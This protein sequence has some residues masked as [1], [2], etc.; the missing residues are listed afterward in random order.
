M[1]R[2]RFYEDIE[3]GE[4]ADLG[5]HAMTEAEIV[6]FAER[7]DPLPFHTDPEAAGPHDGVI[8]S[9]HHTLCVTARLAVEGF[10]RGTAAIAGLGI[11]D[12]RWH[13]PV[14]PGDRLAATLEVAGKRPAE[15]RPGA[16]VIR[17]AV[18]GTVGG[19]PVITYEGAALVERRTPGDGRG[20]GG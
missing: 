20:G 7:W 9:G 15:S 19:E 10:R 2:R 5:S 3:V 17:E 16:G 13:R 18:T 4:R 12:L 6:S 1:D 8:A 14:R 11:D